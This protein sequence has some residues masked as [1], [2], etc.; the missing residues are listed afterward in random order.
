[1]SVEATALSAPAGARRRSVV[2]T[3]LLVLGAVVVAALPGA[4][5]DLSSAAS[6]RSAGSSA[7]GAVY[8]PPVDAPVTD[9]FRP[10]PVPWAPGNRG[11]EYATV[12]GQHVAV[13]APGVVVFAGAVAGALY[14]TVR[15]GDGLRSSYSFLAAVRVTVGEVL[16]ARALV[17]V[18]GAR[19][20]LGVRRGDD[21]IDPATLWGAAVEPGHAR[22][23]ADSAASRPPRRSPV[24]SRAEGWS[25][26]L[27]PRATALSRS[28]GAVARALSVVRRSTTNPF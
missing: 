23:V 4:A 27:A 9:P 3:A 16:G 5:E 8:A 11:I 20:H 17:G 18:A 14:V 13:I 19:L 12:P 26:P 10:P 7:A 21:Y 25:G 22:L 6:A 2:T 28:L 24:G 15:H 1:M